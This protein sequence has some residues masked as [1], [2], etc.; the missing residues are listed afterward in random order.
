EVRKFLEEGGPEK[1]AQVIDELLG[2]KEFVDV[3]VMKWAE[4]LQVRSADQQIPMSYKSALQYFDWLEEQI[5]R[6]VPV[7][8]MVR[9]LLTATGPSFEAP[10]ANFYKIERDTLKLSENVAQAFMGVRVQCAQCHNHPFDRWTMNDY[11]SFAAFFA[12]VGRKS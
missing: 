3:W 7:D 1:R 6:N 4:L 9:N 11:Y 10:A 8:V 5:A 12:Q 2:R